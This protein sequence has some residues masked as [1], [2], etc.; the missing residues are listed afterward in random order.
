MSKHSQLIDFQRWGIPTPRFTTISYNWY[1]QG[2]RP[3]GLRFPVAVR[4]SYTDED[5]DQH[6]Q[7]GHFTTVLDVPQSDLSAAIGRVFAS[8][9]Q[10]EGQVV[11]VQEM[12]RADY[13]G[14]LFAFRTGAWVVEWAPGAGEGI[15]SG[16]VQPRRL[17]LPRFSKADAR[18]GKWFRFWQPPGL[19]A[20]LRPAFTL[21]AYYASRLLQ[22][23]PEVAHGLDIEFCI[24]DGRLYLLQGRPITTPG[25]AQTLLTSANHKEILPPQPSALMTSLIAASGPQLFDYYRG[26]DPSL[27]DRPFVLAA[28]GM[29]WINLSALYD[30][31]VHWGLP[32][33]LV[34]RSVGAEDVY[35]VGARPWRMLRKLPV[36]LQVGWQQQRAHAL[37]KTWV[38]EQAQELRQQQA[39]RHPQWTSDPAGATASWI[40][41]VQRTYVGLVHRMQV[42]TGAMAGPVALLERLGWTAGLRH[43][44]SRS[45]DYFLA[46]TSL[47]RDELSQSA[48]LDRFG[49]R[50]F[51]ESDLSQ[52]R[53]REYDASAWAQLLAS[54]P[55]HETNDNATSPPWWQRPLLRY[56]ARLIHRREWLRDQVMRSF[57]Q[58][59]HELLTHY[60]QPDPW[61]LTL[62]QLITRLGAPDPGPGLGPD[63][64]PPPAG[65]DMD[66]FLHNGLGRRLPLTILSGIETDNDNQGLGIYPGRV[67]G[68]VWRVH[69]ADLQQ[70]QPPPFER[71]IL[72]ADALDPGW[73]PFFSRV[74]GV[75]TY[76]GG[77]LSHASIILREMGIPAVTQLPRQP[78]LQTGD[79]V[80]LD[81]AQGTVVRQT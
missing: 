3:A 36:F 4:S 47:L 42:L 66:T 56:A 81:G 71:I 9:P 55:A 43:Y 59:R 32:T 64:L 76:T 10:P 21:L 29:P 39:I 57:A 67:E 61:S 40:A 78:D 26:L 35:G 27:P 25:E 7:A 70:L 5:G 74:Q 52:P 17:L 20:A 37:V 72:V 38:T 60:P 18:W 49:H 34:A 69:A 80:V 11:I 58:L 8:Y 22:R 2:K 24:A 19:P 46:F 41:D 44:R 79:R 51:Y 23:Q 68:Q 75:A 63:H 53:F 6:S 65:W 62:R 13:S 45:S 1:Q 73:I 77:L 16:Q 48:F 28:A 54:P 31:M 33:A 15:V 50:G 30:T 14:V 12:I